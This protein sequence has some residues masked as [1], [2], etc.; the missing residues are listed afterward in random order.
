MGWTISG[1]GKPGGAGLTVW[2][3]PSKSGARWRFTSNAARTTFA[4]TAPP[5]A[6]PAKQVCQAVLA[7]LVGSD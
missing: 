3:S 2:S 7:A 5:A 4:K 1:A 6:W